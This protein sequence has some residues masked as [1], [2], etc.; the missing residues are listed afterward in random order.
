MSK[1]L[2][3]NKIDEQIVKCI[4]RIEDELI[5]RHSNNRKGGENKTK[6]WVSKKETDELYELIQHLYETLILIG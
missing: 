6:D 2:Q 5:H 3:K 1:K 4:G